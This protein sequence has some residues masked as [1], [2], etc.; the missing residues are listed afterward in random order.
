MST[1][2]SYFNVNLLTPFL[3]KKRNKEV[4]SDW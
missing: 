3:K 2:Y 4:Y 1:V